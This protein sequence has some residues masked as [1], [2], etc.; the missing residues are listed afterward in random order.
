[1]HDR[2]TVTVQ[3][4]AQVI[5]GPTEVDVGNIDMPMLMRLER[6]LKASALL[7]RLA[8]PPGQHAGL[9]QYPP[10][11][12]RTDRHNLCIQHHERQS[13]I[14]LQRILQMEIDDRFFLPQLQPEIAG[15][16]TVV[17]VDTTDRKSTR[18]NSS[19][20]GISYA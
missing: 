1:M 11:P 7:R 4:A 5:E 12:P 13:P 20:L 2:T 19:H 17:F 8:F 16:P 6:L 9:P 3:N 10:N 14:T 15:N 18:L